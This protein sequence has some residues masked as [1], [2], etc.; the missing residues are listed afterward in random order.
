MSDCCE[1]ALGGIELGYLHERAQAGVDGALQLLDAEGDEDAVFAEQRDGVG[2]GG[3]GEQ[4]EERRQEFGSGKIAVVRFVIRFQERLGELECDA[5][6]A[7]VLARILALGLIGIEDGESFGQV[8][9]WFR[10]GG[11]R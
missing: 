10:A 8:R 6:S 9:A 2:Y 3:D 11:G 1:L 5:C 4:L 7:E